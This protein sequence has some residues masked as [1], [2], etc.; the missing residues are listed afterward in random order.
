[1]VVFGLLGWLAGLAVAMITAGG[2]LL[3]LAVWIITRF[4]EDGFTP[5][6]Q[7]RL[8]EAGRIF[9]AGI[10]LVRTDRVVVRLLAVTVLFNLGAEG[11]DRLTEARLLDLGLP[12][13]PAPV[14]FFTALGI[15]GLLGGA[16]FLR[17]LDPLITGGDDNPTSD[18]GPTSDDGPRLVY[19]A[20]AIL[21]A[22]GALLVAVA[23]V[24]AIGAV[25]VFLSRGLA[26]SVLPVVSSVWINRVT[27]SEVRATVQSFLGQAT[28]TGQ[29][30]G[31]L[32]LGFVT[33]VSGLPAAL[34]VSAAL[35]ACSGL[36]ILRRGTPR[37]RAG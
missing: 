32:L 23:P 25:G 33:S 27:E 9:R 16:G 35:F 18:G 29:I 30:A 20:M 31:G 7:R 26:W 24:A 13:R 10:A 28:S 15:V 14:L 1:L 3:A 5:K 37:P 19:G 8:Y 17:L 4:S 12:G 36:L 22:I 34:G 21:A 6:Q 11:M 2:L